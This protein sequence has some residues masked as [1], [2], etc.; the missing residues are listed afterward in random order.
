[1]VEKKTEIRFSHDAWCWPSVID[2][3]LFP[4]KGRP[5]RHTHCVIGCSTSGIVPAGRLCGVGEGV[6]A[7]LGAASLTFVTIVTK[8]GKLVKKR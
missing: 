7:R 3:K 4:S 6:R 5:T 1:M 8:M 2:T